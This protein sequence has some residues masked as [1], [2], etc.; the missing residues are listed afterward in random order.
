M[1]AKKSLGQNFFINKNLGEKIL[2]NIP[3]GKIV[4]E[5]GPGLGFFTSKLIERASSLIVI[6]K[7][8]ELAKSLQLSYPNLIVFNEDF[9][10]FDLNNLPSKGIFFF[11]SLPYNVSKPIIKK[12]IESP[13]F[14]NPSYFIVQKEVA[15]KYV[16]RQPFNILSLTTSIYANVKKLFDIKPD[17]FKPKPKVTSALIEIKPIDRDIP[18]KEELKKLVI[19]SFKHPRK[20]LRNNLKNTQFETFIDSFSEKRASDISLDEYLQILNSK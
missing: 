3:N 9:L 5:I 1:K 12:V 11:G 13:Y 14:T 19:E 17:S 15:D 2:S 7:D 10:S 4:V 6:E 18:N 8:E 20:N 16:Y